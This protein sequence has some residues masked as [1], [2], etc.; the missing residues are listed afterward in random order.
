MDLKGIFSP[1]TVAMPQW[2]NKNGENEFNKMIDRL[3]EMGKQ[4]TILRKKADDFD[5]DANKT[6]DAP[7]PAPEPAMSGEYMNSAP[8]S[9][10]EIFNSKERLAQQAIAK[11]RDIVGK[12]LAKLNLPSSDIYYLRSDITRHAGDGTPA[13]G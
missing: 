10:G 12:Q 4:L 9:L 1:N 3:A 2:K 7:V 5:G 8:R 13:T 11:A 6:G